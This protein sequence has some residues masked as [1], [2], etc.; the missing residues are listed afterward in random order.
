MEKPV[1]RIEPDAIALLCQQ[2]WRGNV[3]ELENVMERIVALASGGTIGPEQVRDCV[4]RSS[5]DAVAMMLPANGLDLEGVM[6]TI[7]KDLL[8]KALQRASGV[9]KDAAGLLGLDF[10]S[11][12]YRL[13]KYGIR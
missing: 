3:R 8:L 4:P 10:R 7:E 11:F 5:E 6:A 2:E 12:R 9:K 13:S 1:M